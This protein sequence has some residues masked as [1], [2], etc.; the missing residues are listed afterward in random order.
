MAMFLNNQLCIIHDETTEQQQATI[1]MDLI[2]D[3]GIE[4]IATL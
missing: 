2:N 4:Y 3:I 1:E